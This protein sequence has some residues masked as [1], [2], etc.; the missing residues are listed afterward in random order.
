ML[1]LNTDIN[2]EMFKTLPVYYTNIFLVKGGKQ[3]YPINSKICSLFNH[4]AN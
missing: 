3:D 4:D 1:K 2:Q